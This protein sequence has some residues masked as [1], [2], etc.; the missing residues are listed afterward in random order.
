MTNICCVP[1]HVDGLDREGEPSGYLIIW[2]RKSS[3]QIEI[4]DL[5][6]CTVIFVF[7]KRSEP[8]QQ[9]AK[10]PDE[11]AENKIAVADAPSNRREI[12]GVPLI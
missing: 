3:S 6:N 7:L 10:A 5:G 12:I 4:F 1:H 2:G 9:R 8:E 11:H